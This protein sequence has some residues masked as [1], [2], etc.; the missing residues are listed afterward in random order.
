MKKQKIRTGS[1]TISLLIVAVLTFTCVALARAASPYVGP[2]DY[3][4]SAYE[5]P[6][7]LRDISASGTVVPL[8]NN[9]TY[10][11][12]LDDQDEISAISIP[13]PFDF[14][15]ISYTQL[16]I[17]S[18][19]FI[20]FTA[21]TD[22]GCCSGRPLPQNDTWNNLIA[23]FWEDLSR[24]EGNIRYQTLGTP[25]NRKFVIGFY[26]VPHDYDN[27]HVTFEAILHEATGDIE[28]QYG[29]AP[30][31][32]ETHSVGIENADGTIGLEI[33]FGDVSF[34]NQGFLIT[35]NPYNVSN[36][37]SHSRI[38]GGGE[39]MDRRYS[40]TVSLQ[41]N[42]G[43]FCGGSLIA[44]D[45]VLTAAHCQGGKYSVVIDRH[46]LG[47][48]NGEKIDMKTEIFHPKYN[49]KT[50]DNDFNLV[51]LDRPT[52]ANVELVK[53]NSKKSV[54]DIGE[55]VTVM[56]WGD[57]NILGDIQDLSDVLMKVDV[58]VISNQECDDSE[59]TI[60]GWY[61]SYEGQITDQMLCAKN[62]K[63][64]ACQGDSGGPLV[65]PGIDKNGAD[66]IQVGVVSWGIGCASKNFPGVYARV[67]SSYEWI[68]QEVCKRS[69]EPPA[70][71]E[72]GN[73]PDP[74]P[75]PDPDSGEIKELKNR[76]W[77]TTKAEY[78][79]WLK[80]KIDV[81]EGV[82]RLVVRT[83]KGTGDADLYVRYDKHPSKG[84]NICNPQKSKCKIRKPN[85]GTYYIFLYAEEAFKGVMLK[86]K[87][88]KM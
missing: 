69:S 29:E 7:N 21:D 84:N 70:Y 82:N 11:S 3:G 32:G 66:D 85:A 63:K 54:P 31:N 50:T 39:A 48:N 44:K 25:G 42:Y 9:P 8:D 43:H 13:F 35:T 45:V 5:I 55:E 71:F 19:G 27:H 38:I 77:V 62:N 47:K 59:G 72:C 17:S 65:I 10:P 20:T 87:Y 83:K 88:I 4:Y 58:N 78:R 76:K 80:F 73:N 68:R 28:L 14:Y 40:Y 18:N 67:S 15:G 56:G 46:D 36:S 30:G 57:T 52:T 2:D 26:S 81:P 41:D 16:Y 64:D 33:A 1:M 49:D 34:S 74:D 51:I 60:D 86:A 12:D 53:L 6:A 24:P 22:A 23:L 61:D 37:G 75:D 79:G